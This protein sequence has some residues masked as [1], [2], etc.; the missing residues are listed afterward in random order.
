MDPG[1]R[2]Q[3]VEGRLDTTTYPSEKDSLRVK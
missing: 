2:T 1:G 3:I